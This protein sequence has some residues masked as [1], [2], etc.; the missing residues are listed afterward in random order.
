M[1]TALLVARCS[2]SEELQIKLF[3][4]IVT[5]NGLVEARQGRC[6]LLDCLGIEVVQRGATHAEAREA[7]ATVGLV[8]FRSRTE[9][10]LYNAE[11]ETRED[12]TPCF[13]HHVWLVTFLPILNQLRC[14]IIVS[15]AVIKRLYVDRE[16][17]L[18][19]LFL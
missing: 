15:I 11:F 12:R 1:R 13:M 9:A 6:W 16:A 19:R 4:K 10:R 17:R 2:I 14:A 8:R 3:R 18:A 7:G 5:I